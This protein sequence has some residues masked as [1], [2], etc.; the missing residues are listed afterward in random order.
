M[1][2]VTPYK[3]PTKKI[4][5]FGE[6]S[7]YE[8]GR[9]RN[10][11]FDVN[12]LA[13]FEQ[14]M[15]MGFAQLM[16]QKAMFGAARAML[17][18]GLKHEDRRLTLEY[19]GDL[20]TD[21]LMDSEFNIQEHNIDVILS[22]AIKAAVEH[23]ALGNRSAEQEAEDAKQLRDGTDPNAHSPETN[24]ASS[25]TVS[26]GPSGSSAPSDSPTGN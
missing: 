24:S 26:G 10:L 25:P 2:P 14:E 17:W 11:K 16:Q 22:I 5:P 8:N 20:L 3:R 12:A 9:I 18:A 6:F 13:D 19:V 4:T 7:K 1:P 23:G 15:G 21:W